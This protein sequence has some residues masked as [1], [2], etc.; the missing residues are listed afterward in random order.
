[1]LVLFS[2]ASAITATITAGTNTTAAYSLSNTIAPTVNVNL[3]QSTSIQNQQRNATTI[4]I[5]DVLQSDI[6]F[7]SLTLAL[8]TAGLLDSLQQPGSFT[9]FAPT[10]AALALIPNS[11]FTR[12]LQDSAYQLHLANV[13]AFHFVTTQVLSAANLTNGR[14]LLMANG[15][16]VTV[17]NLNSQVY[18]QTANNQSAAQLRV[19]DYAVTN[20]G[21]IHQLE[22]ALLPA[23][24]YK[25]VVDASGTFF[26]SLIQTAGLE[27]WLRDGQYTILL[28]S[29]DAFVAL[30]S[31]MF[32][33]VSAVK[34]LVL[35]HVIEKVI[36]SKLL[37]SGGDLVTANG[38]IL[39]V[40][41]RK[42][43]ANNNQTLP[44]FNGVVA[45]QVDM[46]ASNGILYL[47]DAV[48]TPSGGGSD[49]PT[50]APTAIVSSFPPTLS[51][52]PVVAMS[53]AS[54]A[55]IVN[56]NLVQLIAQQRNLQSLGL[57]LNAANLTSTLAALSNG[58]VFAPN[59]LAFTQMDPL[60]LEKLFERQWIAH[61]QNVLLL[62]VT[63]PDALTMKDLR[64]VNNRT[65]IML[66]Q[67]IVRVT[68]TNGT[69]VVLTDPNGAAG[70]VVAG[71]DLIAT[72]G[73]AHTLDRV[74][75]PTWINATVT[76]VASNLTDLTT[77]MG[78]VKSA[79]LDKQLALGNFTLLAP[80]KA[81]FVK[82]ASGELDALTKNI[83]ALTA[84]LNY[85]FLPQVLPS[86][87]VT[88]GFIKTVQ[89]NPVMSKKTSSGQ[90]TFNGAFV[91][92]AD[93]PAS[94]GLIYI[95]DAVLT[96]NGDNAT[97]AP[98]QAPTKAPALQ[99][100]PSSPTRQSAKTNAAARVSAYPLQI[101]AIGMAIVFL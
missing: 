101:V 12:L 93:I 69:S 47:I 6:S 52:P 66:N 74:L 39:R 8:A 23:F 21:N 38:N 18:I 70:V 59:D 96:M 88:S 91:M 41:V 81:A 31:A 87:Q 89:G 61:L 17:Q 3:N 34:N 63:K 20:N 5:S 26:K 2:F 85:H 51:A 10:N 65:L 45:T 36:P 92:E 100:H 99:Q 1:M 35:G 57:A 76:D 27:A 33:N 7:Q 11:Y 84:L 86:V 24:V 80:S 73:I 67:E 4:T 49:V 82:L 75:L 42:N 25:S 29:S 32:A 30:P 78:L 43:N 50:V 60:L 44:T 16:T 37:V 14:Q 83:T 72:N 62:H 46:L 13:L 15:E 22:S 64:N 94:N 97:L 79:G 58:T 95:L 55:A 98:T 90:I 53:S 28:P 19:A 71:A 56:S 77:F 54:P 48:L 68:T 9:L 40:Q